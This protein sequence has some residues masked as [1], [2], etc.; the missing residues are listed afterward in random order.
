MIVT[1]HQPDFLPWIGFF[2]RWQNSDLYVVLDDVQFLRRGWHHRDKIKVK[3]GIKWLTVPV[4][5]KGRYFQTI[6]NVEIDY[7]TGWAHKHLKTLEMNYKKAQNFKYFHEKLKSVYGK[8][9]S[10][11]MDLNMD[12][13][14]LVAEELGI[15]TPVV[16]SSGYSVK[17]TSTKKLVDLIK[18]VGG[19]KYLTG[20]G[21]KGYL[22]ESL[23]SKESIKVLW[24]ECEFPIYPQLHGKF[25]KMLSA[26]DYLMVSQRPYDILL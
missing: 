14:H 22:D 6:N 9:H 17:S 20:I 21:S 18:A 11:L 13:L 5:K 19:N 8:N 26:F 15:N 3:D 23:F 1:I 16:F 10:L 7:S 25:E 24:Q 2:E 4:K 12:L